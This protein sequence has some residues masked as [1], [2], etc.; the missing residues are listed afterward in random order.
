LILAQNLTQADKPEFIPGHEILTDMLA[1]TKRTF[2]NHIPLKASSDEIS[3]FVDSFN[4]LVFTFIGASSYLAKNSRLN[5]KSKKY[6]DYVKNTL[7][8][9]LLPSLTHLI[10]PDRKDPRN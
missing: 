4:A 9:V 8:F 3:M 10:F 2:E 7:L 1:Q 6:R 5:P